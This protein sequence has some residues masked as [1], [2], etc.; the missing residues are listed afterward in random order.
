MKQVLSRDA[1]GTGRFV[2]TEKTRVSRGG[3][4]GGQRFRPRFPKR[5][6]A[7]LIGVFF[8]SAAARCCFAREAPVRKDAGKGGPY[9]LVFILLDTLRADHLGCYGYSRDTS[10]H[11]DA[12]ARR[13]ILFEWAIAPS[14]FTLPS[15]ASLFVSKYV[16]KHKVDRIERCLSQEELTL[17][18]ILKQNGYATAAFIYNAL[19]LDPRFGLGQGFEDYCYGDAGDAL[20]SDREPSFEKTLP[21]ALDWIGKHADRKFFVFLH[22]NDIHEPYE[23]PEENFFDPSYRGRLDDEYLSS[24]NP[25]FHKNN[26]TRT[27]REMRHIVAHYDGGIKYADGYVGTFVRALEERGLL[28]KTIVVLLSDHGEI[29]GDRGPM[30]LHGF[31]LHDEEVRVPLIIVHPGLERRGVRIKSQVQMIDVFPT[32]LDFL[33]VRDEVPRDG[34]SLVP[35]IEGREKE[36]ARPFAY[37]ECLLGESEKEGIENRV[38]MVRTT[39]WKLIGNFFKMD[40]DRSRP[41]PATVQMHNY[42]IISL[43][44]ESGFELYDLREDPKEKRNLAGRGPARVEAAML[45]ELGSVY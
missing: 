7:V 22:A 44:R 42:A 15:H 1:A 11:I 35:L 23:S 37:A 43:P 45:D 8:L 4:G 10:P 38:V 34:R 26:F 40:P 20:P 17:A 13:G 30:F 16:H 29:L 39:A 41:W 33:G 2:I 32:V 9:N 14:S 36:G 27:R 21:Q 12:L 24:A 28:G 6:A 31:S 25:S 3:A 5:Q 18:E 19:Q